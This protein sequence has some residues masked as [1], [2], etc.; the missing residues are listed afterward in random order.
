MLCSRLRLSGLFHPDPAFGVSPYE[1]LFLFAVPSTL[2]SRASLTLLIMRS[3][4]GYAAG[5]FHK[6][7]RTTSTSGFVRRAESLAETHVLGAPQ[8]VS[9]LGF[10]LRGMQH[11]TGATSSS[12]AAPLSRFVSLQQ[13]AASR[14]LRVS[15]K[16]NA[17]RLS[18]EKH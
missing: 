11:S 1:D 9:S 4:D 2:S 7:S 13:A 16:S 15:T 17:Q 14:R 6:P 18:C 3:T 8:Q 5:R 10:P 12:E